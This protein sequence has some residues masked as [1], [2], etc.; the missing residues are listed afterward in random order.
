MIN[1]FLRS[2][3]HGERVAVAFFATDGRGERAL[4]FTLLFLP[5]KPFKYKIIRPNSILIVPGELK[6]KFRHLEAVD[7]VCDIDIFVF[8]THGDRRGDPVGG[9]FRDEHR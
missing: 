8:L 4:G 1:L 3:S 9:K 6:P 2:L 7:E 5:K